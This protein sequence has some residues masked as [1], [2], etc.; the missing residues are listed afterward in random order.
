MKRALC[1]FPLC[2]QHTLF[3]S[4]SFLFTDTLIIQSLLV[5][6]GRD[7]VQ[8]EGPLGISVFVG[9]V[10]A[11]SLAGNAAAG[12]RGINWKIGENWSAVSF[13]DCE[14]NQPIKSHDWWELRG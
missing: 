10:T 5:G 12:G 3:L 14:V 7:V 6:S 13:T 9:A 1:L 11:D 4:L 2:L 8:G